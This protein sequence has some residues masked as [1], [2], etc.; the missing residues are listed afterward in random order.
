MP[1]LRL[2][3]QDRSWPELFK[4]AR[5][6]RVVVDA[7][8]LDGDPTAWTAENLL[9]GFLSHGDVECW[10][11][12]GDGPPPGTREVTSAAGF[13]AAAGDCGTVG[14]LRHTHSV[15]YATAHSAGRTMIS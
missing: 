7:E 5:T 4:V 9:A 10:T 11:Y 12:R 8:L 1:R 3:H 13:R 6:H 15:V 2:S 14:K